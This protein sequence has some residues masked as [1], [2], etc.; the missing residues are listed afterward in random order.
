MDW[1][2]RMEL[3][4]TM[5]ILQEDALSIARG[6]YL[7]VFYTLKVSVGSPLSSDVAVELPLDVVNFISLDPPPGHVID[8][9]R[10]AGP[11]VPSK[12]ESPS[13]DPSPPVA[14]SQPGEAAEGNDI[15]RAM[16]QE[17]E[18]GE[19][20]ALEVEDLN[21]SYHRPA[22]HVSPGIGHSSFAQA[23]PTMTRSHTAPILAPPDD[24]HRN[25]DLYALP[26]QAQ[27]LIE[28][29]KQ[30]QLKH[31]MSLD[32]IGSALGSAAAHRNHADGQMLRGNSTHS[33]EICEDSAAPTEATL[34]DDEQASNIY[35]QY[36]DD[37]V[38]VEEQ[39]GAHSA[40]RLEDLEDIPDDGDDDQMTVYRSHPISPQAT[41]YED[42]SEDEV[43]TVLRARHINPL[44]AAYDDY[45]PQSIASMNRHA[46]PPMRDNR[47]KGLASSG[48]SS[49]R[50]PSRSTLSPQPPYS[51]IPLEQR[52]ESAQTRNNLGQRQWQKQA[53]SKPSG[54]VGSAIRPNAVR[55]R[56]DALESTSR[57]FPN[58]PSSSP[59]VRRH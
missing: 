23:Y 35:D 15:G 37:V 2:P 45:L 52:L 17:D 3:T 30:R 31:Q 38:D 44:D 10:V 8:G 13:I 16:L 24:A 9:G 43:D 34:Y 55:S 1:F 58:M 36:Y 12:I 57:A 20:D 5:R 4:A 53:L 42:E 19:T 32:C 54:P 21:Q 51:S 49:G 26:A 50:S 6:R 29:A 33:E 18:E 14:V 56:V 7:E 48:N 27:R 22:C 39:E 28:K 40:I 41:E 25:P 46:P 59:G 11:A 47:R